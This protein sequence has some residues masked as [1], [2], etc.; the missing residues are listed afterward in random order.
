[1]SSTKSR[2]PVKKTKS[3]RVGKVRAF[4]RG[5]VW[6][7]CYHEQGKRHQPR[8]GPDREAAYICVK[9]GVASNLIRKAY[10]K[11]SLFLHK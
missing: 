7:L 6:Y 2:K 10:R 8:V 1:M 4:L 3:F 9:D 11:F 5:K